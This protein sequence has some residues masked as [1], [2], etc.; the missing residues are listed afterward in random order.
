MTI[1]PVDSRVTIDG[2]SIGDLDLSWIPENIHA[3]QWYDTYGE[4]ELVTSDPNIDITELGIYEQAIPLWESKK[5]ELEELQRERL[6]QE[7]LMEEEQQKQLIMQQYQMAS[8]GSSDEIS[9]I[10]SNNEV[11]QTP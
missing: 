5:L 11:S 10:L 4:V 7:R 9:E 1:I 3:V 8:Q 6:E 2:V